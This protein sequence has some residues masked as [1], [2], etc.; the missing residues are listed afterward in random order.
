[1]VRFAQFSSLAG[2]VLSMK[3]PLFYLRISFLV[4]IALLVT[5]ALVSYRQIRNLVT[6]SEEVEQTYRVMSKAE[7]VLSLLKDAE[8]GQRGFMLTHQRAFLEPYTNSLGAID[9]TFDSL[10]VMAEHSSGQ[11][12]RLDTLRGLIDR[13]YAI[14]SLTV[15]YD[16]SRAISLSERDALLARGRLTMDSLRMSI[17]R[18]NASEKALLRERE[19]R[20]TNVAR[21]T[22]SYLLA[23]TAVTIVLLSG[24]FLLLNREL[25]HRLLVQRE[26][27]HKIEALNR[28]NAE[29]EQF[30]YVASHDLQEPLRKIRAFSSKLMLRHSAA[31]SE[32]GQEL[33]QKSEHSAGR[34]QTL[35]DDLLNFSRLIKPPEVPVRTDLNQVV[36][37]VLNDLWEDIQ[38]KGARVQVD[39]LPILEAQP[40]QFRQLFQ[41][42]LSNALKFSRSDVS[43]VIDIDYQQIKGSEMPQG[44]GHLQALD[45]HRIAVSDNGIGFEPQYVEK[46]FVIF[47]RLHGR[48]EYSGTGIGLA[49]CKR[50]VTNHR[51]FIDAQ[52]TP[53]E[54]STFLIYLPVTG[55]E[56]P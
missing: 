35:I 11:Q 53:G 19:S 21:L 18:L 48:L 47:Q 1:M 2:Y 30:A 29:L 24:S 37:D 45:Y 36:H 22:P 56:I 55:I 42:L 44:L 38:V 54:G 52:S 31:L 20:Q 25:R 3:S 26:L 23:L 14:M 7:E 40:T 28:S 15:L 43:P 9:R 32:E 6:Y 4:S 39:P 16:S 33:L 12:A 13:R 10:R 34:M 41:N 46:I 50:V 5:M 51:G 49:I 8:T 27:E 17:G